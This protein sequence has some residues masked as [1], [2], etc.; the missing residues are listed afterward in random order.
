MLT[1]STPETMTERRARDPDWWRGA[2]IYQIYPRSFQDTN[3]D[4]IGDLP[5]ITERLE[6][7]ASLGV[8]AIWLSPFFTSPM[9]DFGYDIADYKDV[10]PMFG[11]LA[12]FDT[13]VE[14]ADTLGIGVIIDLVI[15]HTSDHHPWFK[16][17]RASRDNPK[18]DWY[19][20]ADAKPDGTAPNNWLSIF[21]GP[22]WEWD[23][24]RKQYYM[25][26]FL[27]TQ[28][29]LN[30]HNAEV[31]D[32]VLDVAKF[33]LDRGVAGF[34]L[35]TVNFYFCD[36]QLR[37][38][39]PAPEGSVVATT[40]AVNPYA[41]QIHVYDKN[42]PENLLF[43]ERLRDLM[44]LYPGVTSVGELGTDE[45]LYVMTAAYTEKDKRLHM[46]YSFE[47]LTKD[48]SAIHVR[49]A[50]DAMET[51]IGDG[52]PSWALSNHDFP[53]VTTRW[54]H[55][56][57][58]RAFG[59]LAIALV[60]TLRGT[61]C[62]YQGEELAL[63]EADVPFELLRDP[64]GIRFWPEFKGR[65][66]CR[67]PM[68]WRTDNAAAG[69]TTGTPW[70]PVPPDHVAMS[71]AAQEGD[72]TAPLGRSRAFLNWRRTVPE[73]LKGD[74]LF[75]ADTAPGILAYSR[76]LD[77]SVVH[78]RLNLSPTPA[79]VTVPPGVEPLDGHGFEGS[80]AAETDETITLAGFGA[81]FGR[82][83]A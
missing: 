37:D 65:D 12:D 54:N 36:K 62:L 67:T 76:Q 52:W 38:N 58:A 1:R 64:Y 48:N 51:G 34:R 29:D 43:L 11:R 26:N 79:S 33:W 56:A 63:T 45:D 39:P 13:L 8:D 27:G 68:P 5:G 72:P 82:G 71:V 25:H 35:D 60:T 16:E 80:A 31:Q 66:G 40:H 20:W 53:R 55:A 41:R 42:R 32:A 75:D 61:A 83:Q 81:W 78:C 73:L 70:L 6:Y 15:S 49:E 9:A 50:V 57:E 77:G 19:V 14:R 23:T 69:F 17:S 18:A 47:L 3:G 7:I 24:R 46:T 74:I 4:G 10:D 44:D 59:P 2:V 22:A 30:F 28:P 21:G